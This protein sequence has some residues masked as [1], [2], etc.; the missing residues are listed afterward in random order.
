MVL[1]GSGIAKIAGVPK[2]VEGLTRAGIPRAAVLPIGS[3]ELL[4]LALY[5]IPRTTTL[6]TLVLTGFLGGATVTHIIGG[7]SFVA[8][9][10][11]GLVIWGGAYFRVP[12]LQVLLPLRKGQE[13]FR[14]YDGARNQQPFPTRG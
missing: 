4:C 2:V 8:P 3:L 13:G 7:E 5:L 1:L 14:A 11:V 12:E 6:G 10:L 9:L